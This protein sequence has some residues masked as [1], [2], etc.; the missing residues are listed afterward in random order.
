MN[1]TNHF[2][3]KIIFFIL[4]ISIVSCTKNDKN[5]ASLPE[6]DISKEEKKDD[7][8]K[9]S[10]VKEKEH[11]P[12]PPKKE[13][14]NTINTSLESESV[15]SIPAYIKAENQSSIGFSTSGTITHI[16]FRSGE[17]VK[18]GQILASMEDNQASVDVRTAKIDVSLKKLALDQQEKNTQR[19]EK[20]YKS[21]IVNL[22]TFEKEKNLLESKNLE[23]QSAQAN[24]AGKE[25]I[26]KSTKILSP[27]NGVITKVEKSVGDY[28]S[29]GTS[30]FQMTQNK[31]FKLYA[32]I[33]ITYFNQLKIGMKLEVRNPITGNKGEAIIKRVVPVIDAVSK[34]FDIYA[35][36][37]TFNDKLAPG[38]FLEIKLKTK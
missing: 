9:N 21:G 33:P 12:T 22:A 18:Q 20:Q 5:K 37:S 34:T 38:I 29:T 19:I 8:S 2:K 27:Y 36:V 31:N 28:V 14:T 35:D 6:Q 1:L 30:V 11:I 10:N 24:L 25:F 7:K 17:E 26:L 3:N 4:F 13:E 15:P 16:Y 23:Y 32:Q